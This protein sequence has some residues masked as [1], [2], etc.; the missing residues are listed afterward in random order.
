MKTNPLV[1]LVSLFLLISKPSLS[2]IK[3]EGNILNYEKSTIALKI[4]YGSHYVYDAEVEIKLDGT[5]AFSY[6][7]EVDEI[8]FGKL[9]I[10]DEEIGLFLDPK[11]KRIKVSLDFKNLK[12]VKFEGENV[13]ISEF[14][15]NWLQKRFYREYESL[16]S[17][18]KNDINEFDAY[19]D[20]QEKEAY[21]KLD[22]IKKSIKTNQKELLRSEI[23]NYYLLL[24]IRGGLEK[25][26]I[27]DKGELSEW[28]KRNDQMFTEI[29][30]NDRDKYTPS[31]NNLLV[32]Q[33]E[34]SKK[35]MEMDLMEGNTSKWLEAF[36]VGSL[37]ELIREILK[38]EHNRIL[39]ELG[40][41]WNC[42]TRFKK[43]LSNTILWSYREGYYENLYWLCQKYINLDPPKEMEVKMI[44]IIEKLKEFESNK[45]KEKEGINFY[46]KKAFEKGI[47]SILN[48]ER[49]KGKVLVLDMWGTWCSPCREQFPY[50]KKLKKQLMKE[51]DIAFLYFS[52]EY[53]KNP[54]E[55]WMETVKY[56]NLKGDHYLATKE[57]MRQFRGEVNK[58]I[59]GE[60]P[61]Y[62]IVNRKGE[63]AKVPAAYP[64]DGDKLFKQIKDVLMEE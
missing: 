5:G 64:S 38:D 50:M 57:V 59:P 43:A 29:N 30:C 58:V 7:V 28:M 2:A 11:S 21:K 41:E 17:E 42:S 12:G 56:F 31:Y 46:P 26:Y 60:Y 23:K 33:L 51:K 8:R 55:Y 48:E 3:L 36:E 35:K 34:H 20:L 10:G 54:E 62:I 1:I 49:Y 9:I 22:L 47:L 45:N 25:D 37:D 19:C 63:I 15:N 6:E 39:Y 53:L 4:L 18:E 27:N 52:A 32:A 13:E 61:M 40:K 44:P 14:V 16:T 24:K